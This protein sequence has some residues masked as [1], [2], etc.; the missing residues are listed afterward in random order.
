MPSIG[1]ITPL[2]V[3]SDAPDFTLSDVLSGVPLSLSDLRGGVIVLNFWSGECDWS[4]RYDDYFAERTDQW[5]DKGVRLIHINSNANESATDTDRIAHDLDIMVPILDDTDN[6]VA[7]AYGA[8]TTPHV[9][10]IT[11]DGHLAYQGAVDDTNFRQKEAT[12]N[13]LDAAVAA[14]LAGREPA[15]T[16]TPSYGCTIV[17]SFD[18]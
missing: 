4:R 13:Y 9:F 18:E 14:A 17:R 3:G 12:V 1:E 8:T 16:A 2:A 11:T 15:V 10:V 5:A 6:A 7:D